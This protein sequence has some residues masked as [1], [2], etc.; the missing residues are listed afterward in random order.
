V[1]R[2]PALAPLSRDHHHALGAALRLRRAE[3]ATVEAAVEHFLTFFRDHGSPHFAIEEQLVLPAL[4]SDDA[5]WADA[6]RR[7][8]DDHAAIRAAAETVA[9]SAEPVDV[10]HALGERLDDHVRFEERILFE[11]LERR[12]APEEL[13][14][15]GAAVD[16]AHG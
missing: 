9:A 13:E 1:K 2:S 14:R 15:L 5:E 8:L 10:A 7:V 16:A 6:T 11:I 3:S 4:P 12:L